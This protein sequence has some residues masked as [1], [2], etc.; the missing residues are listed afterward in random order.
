MAAMSDLKLA[1]ASAAD[2]DRDKHRHHCPT[3]ATGPKGPTGPIGPTGASGG[4][5]GPTGNSGSAG[6]TGPTGSASTGP[7]GPTGAAGSSGGLAQNAAMF[8]G[9]TSGTGSP[10]NDYAATVAVGA[11]VPFPQNGPATAGAPVARAS[12]TQFTL[13]NTGIY[14]VSWQVAFNEASQLQVAI[15]GTGVFSTT[16]LSGA[17]TQI[18][19]NT[20][21]IS[22]T[23][24][25]V[26][27]I[28]NPPGNAT[29]LT[30]QP[31]DGS[32]THAQAPSL[33]IKQIS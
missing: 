10:E 17:G 8:F 5:T 7:T 27:T 11:A 16:T 2:C 26:L 32:L 12:G 21:L 31:A 15:G 4:P 3:G 24:G 1:P 18:N 6:S 13:A 30:V 25:N 28:I 9:T 22:A 33:V 19:S 14:E 20:V 23:A 29:A